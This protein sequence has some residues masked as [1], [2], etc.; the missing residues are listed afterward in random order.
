MILFPTDWA[1]SAPSESMFHAVAH[2]TCNMV[3]K[4]IKNTRMCL[5]LDHPRAIH[6]S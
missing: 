4:Y 3:L 5:Q 2:D 1:G 6:L